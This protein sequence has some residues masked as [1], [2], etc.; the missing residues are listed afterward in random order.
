MDQ[1]RL[2]SLCQTWSYRQRIFSYVTKRPV[3]AGNFTNWVAVPWF[4]AQTWLLQPQGQSASWTDLSTLSPSP[5]DIPYPWSSPVLE[6][7]L[8]PFVLKQ[9][10]WGNYQLAVSP[11]SLF[12]SISSKEQ[13]VCHAASIAWGTDEV[14]TFLLVLHK[15]TKV[16]NCR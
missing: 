12:C 5:K 3:P 8:S 14:Y 7:T 10:C 2:I 6:V 9:K 15:W 11:S 13:K 4:S 16:D 1:K